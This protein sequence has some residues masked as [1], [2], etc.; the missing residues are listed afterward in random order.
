[1]SEK[2]REYVLRDHAADIVIL[3]LALLL[4]VTGRFY[5]LKRVAGSSMEPTYYPGDLL[6]ATKSADPGKIQRGSIV[7]AKAQ[8][9]G[10]PADSCIVK[11]V[12]GMPGDTLR[13]TDGMLYV[14]GYADSA[15]PVIDEPGIL[16]EELTVPERMYFLLGDNC[17]R[18]N[19]SRAFGFVPEADITN[20]VIFKII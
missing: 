5:C 6:V 9:D 8:G 4:L 2:K 11:R 17:R 7:I 18:S 3:L 15:F 1:M 14:N 13:V 12:A 20:I 19:D 10:G 16:S